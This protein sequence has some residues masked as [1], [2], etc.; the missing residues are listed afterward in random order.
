MVVAGATGFVGKALCERLAETH[1]VVGLTRSRKLPDGGRPGEVGL[2]FRSCDLFSLL[3]TERALEGADVAFYLIHSMLPSARLTQASFGDLDLILADN[4]ARAAE[5]KGVKQIIYLGGIIPEHGELSPHLASRLEVEKTFQAYRTPMTAL[6]ASIVIGPHGS[7]F[8]I[9]EGLVRRL[10][11]LVAPGWANNPTQPIAL[12]DV[13]A[14]LAFCVGRPEVADRA[15]DVAG[16]DVVTYRFLL[17][18]TARQLGLRRWI[19]VTRLIPPAISKLWVSVISGTPR[20]LVSPLVESLRHPMVASDRTLNRLAGLPGTSIADAIAS[21]LAAPAKKS[22]PSKLAHPLRWVREASDVRSVQRLPLPAHWRATDVVHEYARWLPRFMFPFIRVDVKPDGRFLFRA[23]FLPRPLLELTHSGARSTRGPRAALHHRRPAR[24]LARPDRRGEARAAH[25]PHPPR[26]VRVPRGARRPLPPRGDPRLRAAP[27]LVPLQREPGARAQVGDALVRAPSEDPARSPRAVGAHHPPAAPAAG[28]DSSR[29]AGLAAR[30]R[31]HSS[32]LRQT[33]A[34][35]RPGLWEARTTMNWSAIAVELSGL[36]GQE[37][38]LLVTAEAGAETARAP[39]VLN[40]VLDRSGSMTGAPLVAAVEAAQQLVDA[41]DAKDFVGL[42]AF[43]AVAE[44]KVPL[45]AMDAEGKKRLARA[46]AALE[47]GS[48]TAL[49]QAVTLASAAV[50]RV[51]VPKARRKL[52]VLTDGEPSVGPSGADDFRSLGHQVAGDGVTVHALGLGRHYLPEILQA[53]VQPSGNGFGHVDDP[54]GLPAAFGP[55]LS[56][57]FG[58]VA[59]DAAIEVRPSG[60]QMISCRHAYPARGTD[61]GLKI[62]LGSICHGMPRRALLS[63]PLAG[64]EWTL[65]LQGSC[66][67]AQGRRAVPVPF[68]KVWADSERGR[69]VRATGVELSLVEAEGAAWAAVARK[70]REGAM[71]ALLRA[72]QELRSLVALAVPEVSS[73]RHLDR[74]GDLRML[75]DKGKGDLQLMVRRAREADARTAISKLFVIQGGGSK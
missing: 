52:L 50:T 19:V 29:T 61:D 23:R 5:A 24:G 45:T 2:R 55:L 46:L 20:A 39:V 66:S 51:M 43:D 44:V 30:P 26:P 70:D 14:L 15:F 34:S 58:E 49:H 31:A 63:G 59:S 69:L 75:L 41:A 1:E 71:Q 11:A 38:H 67:T 13:V 22:G 6:R 25:R 35:C 40:L 32:G 65:E 42:V 18:E 56:E 54:G 57:L 74:I 21:A 27:A 72:E 60:F 17:E 37:G 53:F 3:D 48:G 9:V 62:S 7:S 64:P 8:R 12:D 10:P 73:R 68:E 36:S 4:F 33:P 47:P 16:P 28:A